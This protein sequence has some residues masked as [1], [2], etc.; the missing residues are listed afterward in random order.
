M[1]DLKLGGDFR[2]IHTPGEVGGFRAAVGDDARDAETGGEDR[3]GFSGEEFA[4]DG[5]QAGVSG[6]G[7]AL[8]ADEGE[9]AP[10]H[11]EERDVR[12][13]AADVAGEEEVRTRGHLSVP[14]CSNAT[15]GRPSR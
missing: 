12:L 10:D 6:A 13:R 14:A 3:L 2:R 1:R 11:M 5:V 7:V 8:L 9:F 4:E 15:G